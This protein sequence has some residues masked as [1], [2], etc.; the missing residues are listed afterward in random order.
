MKMQTKTMPIEFPNTIT[1]FE[2]YHTPVRRAFR[3]TKKKTGELVDEEALQM[4]VKSE[5]DSIGRG[6]LISTLLMYSPIS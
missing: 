5:N 4:A 3:I 2:R 6:G 1:F